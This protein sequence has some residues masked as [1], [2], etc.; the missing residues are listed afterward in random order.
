MHL[1][2]QGRPAFLHADRMPDPAQAC[3]VLVH[4]ALN[5]HTVWQAQAQALTDAGHAVLAPDLPGHGNSA[6]PA[7]GSVEELADWLLALLGAAG[8]TRALLAGHSMGSLVALE[9]AARAPHKVAGLTL[10]GATWPMRVSDAL[11]ASARDDEA[12]AIDMVATWSHATLAEHPGFAQQAR[13]SMRRLAAI[14]PDGLL[15]T[16]LNACKTYAGGA[17]AVAALTCPL[18]FIQGSKDRMT[19]PRSA[20]RLTGAAP[21]ARIVTVD[22]GHAMM[23]EAAAAVSAALVDFAGDVVSR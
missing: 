6:G 18:L 22:A 13:E 9:A 21:Q 4:G 16:D 1:D 12:A 8:V 2:V 5:D 15:Y 19:P 20:D 10:L 3:V 23:A 17:A 7:L 11:L 14:N